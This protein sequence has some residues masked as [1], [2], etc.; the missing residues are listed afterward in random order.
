MKFACD[1]C[2]AEFLIADEKVG[3][4]GVKVRC[5]RCSH[6]IIVRPTPESL[7]S[8]D[9]A[10]DMEPDDDEAGVPPELD[11]ESGENSVSLAENIPTEM[12][13]GGPEEENEPNPPAARPAA[14]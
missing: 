10:D 5:K 11:E 1:S 13:A 7:S 9:A 12:E 8:L 3:R 14:G 2:Q 6:V 4:R